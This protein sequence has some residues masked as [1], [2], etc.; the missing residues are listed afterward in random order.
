MERAMLR[1]I[2]RSSLHDKETPGGCGVIHGICALKSIE[3]DL[4]DQCPEDVPTWA[5][6]GGTRISQFNGWRKLRKVVRE[7]EPDVVHARS[8]GTWF[9]AT[10]AVMGLRQPRLLLS[11]H[12]RTSLDAPGLRRRLVD[13]WAT[14]R[15]HSVLTV[16][17]HSA[18]ALQEQLRIPADKLVTIHNGV[19]TTHYCPAE[20]EA[21]ILETRH[22]LHLHA[23]ADVA[24]CVANLLP[25]KSLDLLVRAWRQIHMADPLARLLIVGEGPLRQNLED[26]VRQ[27]RC[28]NIIR[29]LGPREDVAAILRAADVFVLPSRYEGCSNA[30]LEAMASGLP[31]VAC[32][33]GGMREL[34]AHNR[35]GW[36]VP[37]D[38]PDTLSQTLLTLL[39][40]RSLR[41]R[42]GAAGRDAAMKHFGIDTWVARHAAL[43]RRLAG[44]RP[45]RLT[46]REESPC[47]E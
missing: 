9:D 12:G 19:D 3:A 40:D 2:Q 31:V 5:L 45:P 34:V 8:K 1:L 38:R 21:E 20:T 36:L 26:L 24:V 14:S 42:A 16:S 17:E 29:F 23:S 43:Y 4:A 25:I 11:F 39:L 46:A 33:V 10:A 27:S 18:R 6:N 13:R 28:A 47:A 35:T 44:V 32:D 30:T 15:S 22:L 7:F 37:P 41:H